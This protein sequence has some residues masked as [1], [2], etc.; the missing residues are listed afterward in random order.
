MALKHWVTTALVVFAAIGL[1]SGC[2]SASPATSFYTLTAVVPAPGAVIGNDTSPPPA[3]IGVG[4]I[5]VPRMLNRAQIVTRATPN[6]VAMDD[7]H[8]WAGDLEDNFLHVLTENLAA[9]VAPHPVR[10]FPWEALDAPRYRVAVTVQRLDGSLEDSVVMDVLWN[11]TDIEAGKQILSKRSVVNEAVKKPDYESFVA[12]QSRAIGVLSK[13][14][15]DALNA[16][17]QK[18]I[19][20]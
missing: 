4:P 13:E 7:F 18:G 20:P 14:M 19:Q 16:L 8:R 5:S 3:I 17:M 6:R 2:R 10:A 15:A 1:T 11:I 9:L 12:A